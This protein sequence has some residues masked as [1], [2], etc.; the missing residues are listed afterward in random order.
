MGAT[1]AERLRFFDRLRTAIAGASFGGATP[2]ERLRFFDPSA[3]ARRAR[4]VSRS[5]ACGEASFLRR[6]GYASPEPS[7]RHWSNACGEASFLRP[8]RVSCAAETR[9]QRSNACGEASFLR[10]TAKTRCGGS[11]GSGATP[12]ERLRFFDLW[13]TAQLDWMRTRRPRVLVSREQRLRR[14]F[15]SSTCTCCRLRRG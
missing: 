3:C 13:T 15:V 12:A 7:G 9:F 2:A 8:A 4:R 14:G 11:A 10:P 5:N 1:P 6:A